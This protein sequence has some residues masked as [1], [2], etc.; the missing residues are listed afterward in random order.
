M[1]RRLNVSSTSSSSNPVLN[2]SNSATPNTES[3]AT[4]TN[5]N[6][7]I[8]FIEL[9]LF[10]VIAGDGSESILDVTC[11]LSCFECSDDKLES[12][13]IFWSLF[14]LALLDGKSTD[15]TVDEVF[16]EFVTL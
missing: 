4:L 6:V 16:W 13:D 10:S 7:D 9:S 1:F 8:L 11:L 5:Y 15:E 2:L 3:T 14:M 12:S